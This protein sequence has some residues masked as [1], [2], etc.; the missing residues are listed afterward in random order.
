[1]HE[2]YSVAQVKVV[3]V[4]KLIPM[5]RHRLIFDTYER[6]KPGEAFLLINDHDPQPLYHRFEAEHEGQFFWNYM[7]QGPRI[8]QVEIGRREEG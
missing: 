2:E 3:D 8:W 1:M 5:Q 4:R 7:Q 6:L